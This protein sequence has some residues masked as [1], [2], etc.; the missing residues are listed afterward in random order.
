MSATPNAMSAGNTISNMTPS[1]YGVNNDQAGLR[2]PRFIYFYLNL[3]ML[4][5]SEASH[6]SRETLRY[7]SG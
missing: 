3:V 2:R 7:R 1:K 5:D 6:I 4:S